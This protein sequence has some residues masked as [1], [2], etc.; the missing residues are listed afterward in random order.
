MQTPNITQA[1]VLASLTTIVGLLVTQGAVTN[2]T[3][4]LIG[5]I[6]AV[7]IPFVW[8]IADAIIRHGRAKVAAA[9]QLASVSNNNVGVASDALLAAQAEGQ[10]QGE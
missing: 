1:Q 5:G 2:G 9:S 4:K 3:G 6:A 7:V 10:G 8:I